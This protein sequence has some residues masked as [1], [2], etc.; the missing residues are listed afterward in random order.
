MAL[1]ER[2][3]PDLDP[4]SAYPLLADLGFLANSDLPDRPGPAYLLVAMRPVP[5]L[6]HFDPE[7]IEYWVTAGGRGSRR[8]ITRETA[9]PIDV[10]FAWGLI[11]IIDRL[12]VSNEYLTFGGRLTAERLDATIV[13]VFSSP[14]PLLRRGGHSQGWDHA[15]ECVGAFLGRVMLSVDFV[16]GFEAAFNA[17][18]TVARYA[19][20][21]SDTVERYRNSATLRADH[22]DLWTTLGTEERR[23]RGAN[24]AAWAD[25][26]SL[27]RAIETGTWAG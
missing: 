20:F 6:H 14:T 22:P 4:A 1:L 16:P 7:R 9:L 17:S 23:I 13:A 19:A 25:G 21:L 5:T 10:P 8:E 15:A 11:R 2:L 27:L 26:V 24:S 18:S 3:P 12:G